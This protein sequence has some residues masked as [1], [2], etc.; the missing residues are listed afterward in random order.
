ML[1]EARSRDELEQVALKW[2]YSLMLRL[3]GP[4][5][6]IRLERIR[7]EL[8]DVFEKYEDSMV[9]P[10][11]DQTQLVEKVIPEIIHTVETEPT[12]V[13]TQV[14]PVYSQ[15][16]E[17]VVATAPVYSQPVETVPENIPTVVETAY[18][19]SASTV[20]TVGTD[21]YEWLTDNG[22]NYYRLA[23]SGAEWTLWQG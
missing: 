18:A 20:G 9:Y 22:Q 21:G 17:P 12:V 14:Q 7:S 1:T 4:H 3:L 15:P 10:G 23:N 11:E 13:E 5:Q 16:F 2:E 19:P 6:G 8:D